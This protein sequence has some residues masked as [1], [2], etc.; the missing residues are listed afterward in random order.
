[1]VFSKAHTFIEGMVV[2]SILAMLGLSWILP[3]LDPLGQVRSD[4][5]GLSAIGNPDILD[6]IYL[7]LTC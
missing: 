5:S 7:L 1:M 6:P 4:A 2:V 3:P